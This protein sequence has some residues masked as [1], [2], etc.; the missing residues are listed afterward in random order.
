MEFLSANKYPVSVN[1]NLSYSLI[2]PHIFFESP[3]KHVLLSI[4]LNL[5]YDNP[6]LMKYPNGSHYIYFDIFHNLD[7]MQS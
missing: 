5:L 3:H 7:L 1:K 2:N 6:K 4:L